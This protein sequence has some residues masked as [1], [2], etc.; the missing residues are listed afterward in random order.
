M[1]NIHAFAQC[2]LPPNGSVRLHD[3]ELQEYDKM[4]ADCYARILGNRVQELQVKLPHGRFLQRGHRG[5]NKEI[6]SKKE[7]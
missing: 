7:R 4:E 6:F 2:H 5:Q 1:K 3:T